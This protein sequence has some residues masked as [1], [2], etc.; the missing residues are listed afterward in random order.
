[1]ANGQAYG[2][3]IQTDTFWARCPR[4]GALTTRHKDSATPFRFLYA[5]TCAEQADF[6]ADLAAARQEVPRA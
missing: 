1:M 5:M 6:L 3:D 2:R 4:C